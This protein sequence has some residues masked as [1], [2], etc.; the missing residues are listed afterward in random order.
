M[1]NCT[2]T[3]AALVGATAL[4]LAACA[5]DPVS[6]GGGN[7]QLTAPAIDAPSDDEQLTTLRPTFVVRNGSSNQNGTRTYE[8]QVSTSD[9]FGAIAVSRAGIA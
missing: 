5:K 2:F 6:P 9:T 3:L 4:T 8:F 1:R 7:A